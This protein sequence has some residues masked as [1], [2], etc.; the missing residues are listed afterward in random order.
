[1]TND[2]AVFLDLDN[3][4]I[5]AK[6]INLT[7]DINLVL[8]HLKKV[9]NGRIV[10]RQA[11]GGGR[12]NREL[13]RE[14]AQAGF[15]VQT[16]TR[17]NNYGKNLADMQIVVN[18]MDTLI[19]G[20]EY[21]TYILM[22]GDRDFTPLVQSLRKRGKQVIGVGIRHTTS[23]SLVELCDQYVYYEDLV[24][25]GALSQE[26]IEALLVKAR[27]KLLH[28]KKQARA[29]LLKQRMI[30]L[31]QGRFS[32][33]TYK[34]SSFTKFLQQFPHIIAL[35]QKGSTTYISWPAK[36][37]A[38][39]PLYRRYRSGLKKQR[40]RITPAN[41]RFLILK[42]LITLLERKPNLLWRDAIAALA[43]R[44]RDQS[45]PDVS[46]NK[47]NAVML[48]ARQ[49]DVIRTRRGKSLSTAP[50]FLALTSEKP[51]QQAVMRCD[52]AYLEAILELPE[53]FDLQ[54]AAVALYDDKSFTSYLRH[55]L[56]TTNAPNE[57][58]D[59]Q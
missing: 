21:T 19:D 12:Q 34:E 33:S 30:D 28:K 51:F 15:T 35:N 3:L 37:K 59:Q 39:K 6:Q 50:V 4:V 38:E 18:A 46:K 10:L 9:T 27:D 58:A 41:Q 5:G 26:E 24:P 13:L 36:Q 22:S 14:L 52:Q 7:F 53:P 57:T 55:I 8:D 2:A 48:V 16:A 49:G 42:E 44:F 43:E 32:K 40:L 56:Q 20:H 17:I 31:S 11:Y 54:E 45:T 29:S 1:M 47:I 23:S 25:Q